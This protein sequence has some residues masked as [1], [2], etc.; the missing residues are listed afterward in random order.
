MLVIIASTVT[1]IEYIDLFLLSIRILILEWQLKHA[2]P[3]FDVSQAPLAGC[4]GTTR[5]TALEGKYIFEIP[6]L[7]ECFLLPSDLNLLLVE[8]AVIREEHIGIES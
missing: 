4:T 7:Q 8:I 5:F 2:I 6:I 3:A 1:L